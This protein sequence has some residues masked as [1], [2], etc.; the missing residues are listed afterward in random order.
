MKNYLDYE[1]NKELGEC[2]LFM[3][4]YEKAREYYEKARQFDDE[5]SAPYMGLATIAVQHGEIQL[6]HDYYEAAVMREESDKTLTG[7]GLVCMSMDKHDEAFDLLK[8]A[9][10]FN[11]SN[12]VAL[13]CLVQEA[14]YLNRVEEIIEPLEECYNFTRDDNI[15]ITLAGCLI[16]IGKND[17]AKQYLEEIL[18]VMPDNTSA[19]DLYAHIA[20]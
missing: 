10:K 15:R 16:S 12:A 19:K 6:A 13:G 9:M 18:E 2:Y 1:I 5:Q 20:A 7:L 8:R 17:E 3:A 11:A 14:Y 4:D